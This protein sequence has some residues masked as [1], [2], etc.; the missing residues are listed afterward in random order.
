MLA[1][2]ANYQREGHEEGPVSRFL[3]HGYPNSLLQITE[4]MVCRVIYP[5]EIIGLTAAVQIAVENAD[6]LSYLRLK[7]QFAS[8]NGITS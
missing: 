5:L 8:L 2:T 3:E 4:R 1:R 6:V 7:R